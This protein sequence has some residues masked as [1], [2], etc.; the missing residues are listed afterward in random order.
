MGV[1]TLQHEQPRVDLVADAI[2]SLLSAT[3]RTVLGLVTGSSPLPVYREP[4]RRSHAG[5]VSFRSA[6]AFTLDEYA[7]P[8]EA[9]LER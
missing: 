2:G 6:S 1:V 9:H 7:G 4:V 8:E 5:R 3:P